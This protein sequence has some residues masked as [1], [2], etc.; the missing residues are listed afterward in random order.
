MSVESQEPP[1]RGAT[2]NEVSYGEA[3]L[4]YLARPRSP[5]RAAVRAFYLRTLRSL[6]RGVTLDYGCGAGE[7][8]GLLAPGSEGA[9]VN[10]EAVA[11]GRA[12]GHAVTTV[13]TRD[14]ELDLSCVRPGRFDTIVLSHVLEHMEDPAAGLRALLAACPDLGVSR[15]VVVVPGAAGFRTDATHRTFVDDAYLA[16][17]G[18]LPPN[19]GAWK[20]ARDAY[21]PVNSRRLAGLV[22]WLEL[23]VVYDR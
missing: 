8:L 11:Y 5:L 4:H 23:Q 16:S 10:E 3:Y 14:G 15:I 13:H 22:P 18:L 20:V 9:E 1:G 17:H 7:L 6:T 21:F 19:A 2:T 12:R